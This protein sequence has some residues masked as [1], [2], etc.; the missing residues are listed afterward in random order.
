MSVVDAL[1]IIRLY[2]YGF[3]NSRC[4][5]TVVACVVCFCIEQVDL[6]S[7]EVNMMILDCYRMPQIV[8][9]VKAG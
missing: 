2:K 5:A 9:Y 8:L 1:I 6:M 3:H 4:T 7:L